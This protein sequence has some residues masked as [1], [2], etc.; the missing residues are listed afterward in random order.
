METRQIKQVVSSVR[1]KTGPTIRLSTARSVLNSANEYNGR[2]QLDSQDVT[3]VLGRNCVIL[4]YT[5]K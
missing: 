2:I 1:R 3:T 4:A 5:G